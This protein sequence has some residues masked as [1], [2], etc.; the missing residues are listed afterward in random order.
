M[1]I[2]DSTFQ[3]KN[4]IITIGPI[5]NFN[6]FQFVFNGITFT[7]VVFL[8][9]ATLVHLVMQTKY[10]LVVQNW[11]VQNIQGGGFQLEPVSVIDETKKVQVSVNNILVANNDFQSSTFFVVA[12][13]CTLTVSNW[14]MKRNSAYF[15]GTI[16]SIID[17][18]STV[19]FDQW[20]F[21]HNNGVLGGLF[22]VERSSIINVTNSHIYG[23]FAVN[24]PVAYIENSGSINFDNWE[25]SSSISL[26]VGMLQITDSINLSTITNSVM[27]SNTF[28]SKDIL[29]KDINDT[30]ICVILWFASDGFVSYLSENMQLLDQQVSILF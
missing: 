10:P 25:I 6:E 8:K 14:T 11:V 29:V 16:L 2:S 5:Y 13:Y 9:D 22:Y 1:A 28:T 20:N 17:R 3:T 24:S 4:S 27:Y 15:L 7:N 30:T 21:N 23:N 19:S 18:K 26:T 12:N